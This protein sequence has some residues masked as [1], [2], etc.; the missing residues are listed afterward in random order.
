MRWDR[1]FDDLEALADAERARERDG[2]VAD[3]TRHER[4]QHDLQARMLANLGNDDVSLRLHAGIVTGR[5]VDVGPDWALVGSRGHSVVIALRAI[6]AL[7][8]LAR[9]ARIPTV[10]ARS[11]TLNGVLRGV[12]RDRSGVEVVD[13]E[14][15]SLTGTVESV[16]ADHVEMVLH[17]ADVPRRQEHLAGRVVVPLW[18]LGTVRRL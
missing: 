13:L 18:S 7:T 3:R 8:G 11:F 14:G 12:S 15:R 1:L 5:L 17:A 4:G 2:E 6:R 10:V 16:G 9:G